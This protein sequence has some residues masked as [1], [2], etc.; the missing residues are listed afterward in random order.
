MFCVVNL[1]SAGQLLHAQ[2]Q[3]AK[4]LKEGKDQFVVVYGTSLS[5]GDVNKAYIISMAQGLKKQR[6]SS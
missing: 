4:S 2:S 6:F 3:L 5:S 1:Y